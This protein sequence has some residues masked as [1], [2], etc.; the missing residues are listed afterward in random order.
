MLFCL[1]MILMACVCV[2]SFDGV[3]AG[4]LVLILVFTNGICEAPV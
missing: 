4:T 1:V 3:V 2:C